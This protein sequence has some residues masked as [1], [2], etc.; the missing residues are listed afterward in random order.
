[1]ARVVCDV[2]RTTEIAR[3]ERLRSISGD[4][5]EFAG[6]AVGD[7]YPLPAI[8]PGDAVRM[9]ELHCPVNRCATPVGRGNALHGV[10]AIGIGWIS[11]GGDQVSEA[12]TIGERAERPTCL[13]DAHPKGLPGRVIVAE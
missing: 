2:G 7:E 11:D 1:M 13:A 9:N 6:S 8:V 12:W 10:G 5:R 4:H 3:D